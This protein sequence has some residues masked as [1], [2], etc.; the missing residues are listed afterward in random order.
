MKRGALVADRHLVLAKLACA[1]LP[2]VFSA[3]R[4]DVFEE[5]DFDSACFVTANGDVEEDDGVVGV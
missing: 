3:F 5:F 4:C 1:E 2:K